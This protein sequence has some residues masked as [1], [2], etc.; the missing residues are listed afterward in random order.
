MK[1]KTSVA[2]NSHYFTL[3]QI[4]ILVLQAFVSLCWAQAPGDG[5]AVCSTANPQVYPDTERNLMDSYNYEN[6]LPGN[7]TGNSPIATAVWNDFSFDGNDATSTT[8]P[9]Y[10][11]V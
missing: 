3:S 2:L 6:L 4:C 10:V 11:S 7:G 8:S 1:H 5:D 9:T